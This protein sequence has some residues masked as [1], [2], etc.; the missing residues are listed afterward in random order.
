M[1]CDQVSVGVH[2]QPTVE[3]VVGAEQQAVVA[4]RASIDVTLRRGLPNGFAVGFARFRT[5]RA[6]V[7]LGLVFVVQ[8]PG[9]VRP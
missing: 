3:P 4:L 9:A 6:S 1:Q 8:G 2:G 5:R 7:L